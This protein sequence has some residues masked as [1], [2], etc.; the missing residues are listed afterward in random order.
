MRDILSRYAD[1]L[2]NYCVEI[3]PGDRLL[4]TTSTLAEPLI[5][6][7]QRS[8]LR[9]GG[10]L[11]VIFSW[12]E[13][14]RIL[15]GEASDEQLAYISPLR[16]I[17]FEE[18]EAYIHIRAPYNLKE[19]QNVDPSRA[20]V[21]RAASRSINESYNRRTADR[22]LRRSLCQY[23]TQ[24]SAQQADMS[25]EEYQ[26]F[27]FN[28][29]KL[30]N[31]DYIGAWQQLGRQQ[32]QVVDYLNEVKQI[33]YQ[34]DKTDI[35]FSVDGRTWINSDGKTNMP[36]GEVYSGPVE[37]SVNG[38]VY[39][40]YPSIYMGQDV[41]GIRLEV[42]DGVVSKW[43]AEQGQAVLDKVFDID[44][45]RQFGEV[46]IG[47]NYDINIPTKNILF[48][49]KIGGTIHMAVGQSY[50][51]T[52]GLNQSTVHWDMIA[53]MSKAATIEADGQVIYRDGHFTDFEL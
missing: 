38:V 52:G 13:D 4:V 37:T 1:L 25:L 44:G 14:Y 24:A 41:R 20:A 31:D 34:N 50:K 39:F 43:S 9:A 42:E 40:D 45:A 19:N 12:Q 30:Y 27:V 51:Q 16:K 15:M 2:I 7:V 8:C 46:A 48:D 10:H 21:R 36:S 22:S 47:T 32:Q 49:E 35:S 5:R 33:R 28:A 3:T 18:F 26:H 17:A 29:C 53:D 6:E 11:E 23:P